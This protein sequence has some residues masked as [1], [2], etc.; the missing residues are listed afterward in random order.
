MFQRYIRG[1]PDGEGFALMEAAKRGETLP[2]YEEWQRKGPVFM[3]A[4]PPVGTQ[5]RKFTDANRKRIRRWQHQKLHR[6]PLVGE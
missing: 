3:L 1:W 6:L 4:V 2:W 5:F